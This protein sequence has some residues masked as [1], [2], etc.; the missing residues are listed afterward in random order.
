MALAF[1]FRSLAVAAVVGLSMARAACAQGSDRTD[2][3]DI[4]QILN[5]RCVVC[6]SGPD[7]PL[8][9]R[10]DSLEHLKSG[11]I[12]GPITKAGQPGESEIIRRIKGISQPRMPLT[13][14][15]FL[16]DE[17]IALFEKWIVDGMLDSPPDI[18]PPVAAHV[19]EAP[20]AAG[21][22]YSHVE[23][24]FLQ[25]CVKCHSDANAAGPPEGLR[26]GTLQ[27]ILT[28]GER[29]VVV[30][31]NAGASELIRRVRGRSLPRMPFDGPPFLNDEQIRLLSD[32]INQGARDTDGASA[33]VPVGRSV[34]MEGILT[35][36]WVLD[37]T[38]LVVNEQTRIEDNLRTGMKVEVRGEV[39]QGGAITA[40]RIRE[41]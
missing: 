2:F 26:L 21:V 29:V 38:E 4:E 5:D 24:I 16:N 34:R 31:G 23:R 36:L 27:Q 18:A 12:N 32:W 11:S 15:P 37:E 35:K 7:A 1:F 19:E 9:L 17:E 39:A 20:A 28:G 14:P 25:R 10:L 3:S 6:H 33:P 8:G 13:G 30:P 41:R 22:L 40:T